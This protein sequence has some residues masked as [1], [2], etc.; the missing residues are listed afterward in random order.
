MSKLKAKRLKENLVHQVFRTIVS[1]SDLSRF[2]MVN[3]LK[4]LPDIDDVHINYV[5]TAPFPDYVSGF[6]DIVL[7]YLVKDWE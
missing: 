1:R 6:E 7:L 2:D 5:E 4:E 3:L